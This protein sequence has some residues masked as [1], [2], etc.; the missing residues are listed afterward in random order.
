VRA[1]ERCSSS[2]P[3]RHSPRCTVRHRNPQSYRVPSLFFD[4]LSIHRRNP[5][6]FSSSFVRLF[7]VVRRWQG[8]RSSLAWQ[9]PQIRGNVGLLSQQ[10]RDKPNKGDFSSFDSCWHSLYREKLSKRA[11]VPATIPFVPPQTNANPSRLFLPNEPRSRISD[12]SWPVGTVTTARG[13]GNRMMSLF[14][15]FET[16]QPALEYVRLSG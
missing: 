10:A 9:S 2:F 5:S 4:Q 16:C 7:L 6:L 14:G 3:V 15:T 8:R 12:R 13:S 11:A 1:T